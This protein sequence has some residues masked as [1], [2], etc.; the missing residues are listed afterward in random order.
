[1]IEADA[2]EDLSPLLNRLFDGILMSESEAKDVMGLIMEDR[3]SKV[4]VAALLAALRTRGETVQEITGFA[5]AMRERSVKLSV[6]M[7][8]PL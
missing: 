2:R 4:Q 3:V 7:D 1:M 5:E 8:T 6:P